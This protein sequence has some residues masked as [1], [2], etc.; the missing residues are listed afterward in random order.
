MARV[1]V[2]VVAA[3]ALAGGLASCSSSS[4]KPSAAKASTTTAAA[5]TTTA[6]GSTPTSTSASRS[7]S[8]S[9]TTASPDT[10][11]AARA[12]LTATDLPGFTAEPAPEPTAAQIAQN[13]AFARCVGS[14]P[15]LVDT[16]I[17][18]G[19]VEHLFVEGDIN[20]ANTVQVFAS[21]AAAGPRFQ[22]YASPAAHMC[23]V[24]LYK[25]QLAAGAAQQHVQIGAVTAADLGGSVNIQVNHATDVAYRLTAT[26]DTPQEQV[27]EYV[28][29]VAAMRGRTVVL[30]EASTAGQ[31]YGAVADAALMNKVLGRLPAT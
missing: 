4:A 20:I 23:L 30:V 15:E 9:T 12:A 1:P 17:P 14:D 26:L 11:I 2:S 18:P 24:S 29:I 31:P 8:T 6:A 16:T 3:L 27:N 19:E 22:A 7:G 21:T 25:S 5:P 28:D 13:R 10:A